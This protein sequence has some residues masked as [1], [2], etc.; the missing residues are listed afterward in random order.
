MS[1]RFELGSLT[2]PGSW[3][4]SAQLELVDAGAS[5]I[6]RRT[7]TELTSP[8][9]ALMQLLEELR[10][11]IPA[12]KQDGHRVLRF[13]DGAVGVSATIR[14]E[15]GGGRTALQ[16]HWVRID[17]GTLSHLSLTVDAKR[18]AELARLGKIANSYRPS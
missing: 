7:A 17:H 1:Q 9:L 13:D 14:A 18:G 6:V 8:E 10:Q 3:R 12:L 11:T 4:A 2:L 16:S 15:I 5:I